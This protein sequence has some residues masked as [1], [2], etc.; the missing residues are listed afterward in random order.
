LDGLNLTDDLN[1]ISR[2]RFPPLS[3]IGAGLDGYR[4][5]QADNKTDKGQDHLPF[6]LNADG[7]GLGLFDPEGES[8]DALYFGPQLPGVSQGVFPENSRSWT[9]FSLRPSPGAP[10]QSDASLQDSDQDGLPDDWEQFFGCNP[11]DNADVLLDLDHDGLNNRVE[12]LAGTDPNDPS[13][14]LRLLLHAVPLQGLLL[15]FQTTPYRVYSIESCDDLANGRWQR[16]A[17]VGPLAESRMIRLWLEGP[18]LGNH[19]Y[20]RLSLVSHPG[21]QLSW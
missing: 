11:S 13:S 10:N 2:Y 21:D 8:I 17:D 16:L 12:Y 4:A 15:S 6:Q 18:V 7:E 20:Y 3:F 1:D 14:H 9:F 5:F 19:S